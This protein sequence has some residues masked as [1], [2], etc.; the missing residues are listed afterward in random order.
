[1]IPQPIDEL[2]VKISS[3]CNI[4]CTYCFEYRLGDNS[5]RG[6]PRM[7]SAEVARALG[8]R[9]GEHAAA[10]GLAQFVIGLH[11]GEPLLVGARR[12]DELI[13]AV[14]DGVH[15]RTEVAVAIQTNA[16]LVTPEIARVLA[17]HSVAVGVSLDGPIFANDRYR[18]DRRGESTLA[19]TLRGIDT[20]RSHTPGQPNGIL[21]VVDP[22]NDPLAVLAFFEDLGIEHLDFLL[23]DYHWDRPP[24]RATG[25]ATPWADWLFSVYEAWAGGQAAS[26]RIRILEQ[27]VRKVVGA[28]GVYE[29]LTLEPISLAVVNPAGGW[30]GLDSLKATASGAQQLGLDVFHHGL[31]DVLAHPAIAAR[32]RGREVLSATCRACRHVEV[33]GGGYLPHRWGRGAAFDNPSVYCTDLQSLIGRIS[34][35]LAAAAGTGGRRAV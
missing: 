15:G 28:S 7:M 33:C 11:G 23:P 9:I 14:M 3:R 27:V 26:L 16:T 25:D 12:L 31:D 8:D 30:E 34:D 13:S 21:A 32:Q 1:M 18:V 29:M 22:E 4:D 20:I 5:W 6:M 24:P 35:H 2:V 19:A 10:H 17:S